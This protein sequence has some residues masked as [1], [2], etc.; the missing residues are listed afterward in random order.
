[1]LTPQ[2]NK[3]QEFSTPLSEKQESSDH[4]PILH[5]YLRREDLAKELSVSPRTIDRWQ[6]MRMGPPRVHIGRTILYSAESVREWLRSK[7]QTSPRATRRRY[8]R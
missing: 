8:H 7:E 5:G 1:M 6:M 3:Q 2:A 4:G